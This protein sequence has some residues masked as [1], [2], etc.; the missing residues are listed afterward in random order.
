MITA[1]HMRG[2]VAS[3]RDV[4]HELWIVHVRPEEQMAFHPGQYI[5]IGLPRDGKL[6]ERPYSVVSSPREREL[7]FFVE[8][9][10]EGSLTPQLYDVPVGGEVHLRRA[11]K[12]RFLFDEKSGHSNHLMVAT[13]TGVAPYLSMLRELV[14]RSKEGQEIPHRIVVIQAA[15]SSGELGYSDELAAYAREYGWLEYVSTVS[16]IWLDPAWPGEKG[17]VEDVTRKYLDAFGFTPADTTAYVCGNPNMIENVKG[18]LQR[19]GFSMES[20]KEEVYWIP[21]KGA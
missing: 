17:R 2:V 19:A 14:A 7:E 1:K 21:G 11:A 9:V 15:S 6:C 8:L 12:G 18:V 3:R 4:S 13:V 10:V 5:T 16:R 20:V